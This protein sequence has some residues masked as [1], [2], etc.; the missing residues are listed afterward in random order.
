MIKA[1]KLLN[2]NS[3]ITSGI[4][5]SR[6]HKKELYIEFRN[7]ERP[8]L[9]K[10]YKDYCRILPKVVKEAKRMAYDKQILNSN[11]V[12]RT[13]WKLINNELGRGNKNHGVQSVNIDGRITENH[14]II[15]DASNKY[16]T[17]ILDTIRK[18]INA[19]YC[20]TKNSDNNHDVLSCSL[21]HAFQNSFP[22]IKCKCTST[23]EFEKI[24][25]SLKSS[26]SFGYDEIPTKI[27]KLCSSFVSSPLNYICNRTLI[28]GVFPDR[29]NYALIRKVIKK[30]YPITGRYQS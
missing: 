15:A 1:N 7:K 30:I 2:Y 18:N 11:N 10:Y 14:Q 9:R 4:K 29:L 22:S 20:Y 12:M 16:F 19:S 24:I 23:K 21:K 5:A 3:W 8:I 13:S 17:T 6:K 25:M 28:T 27:L 26:N